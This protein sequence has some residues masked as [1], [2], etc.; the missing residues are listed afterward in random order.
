MKLYLISRRHLNSSV[1]WDPLF[2]LEN[3]I[4]DTCDATILA[5]RA[6]RVYQAVAPKSGRDVPVLRGI[7]RRTLGPYQACTLPPKKE[8]EACL[9]V[10]ISNHGLDVVRAVP[11]WRERFDLALAYMF[12]A[13]GDPTDHQTLFDR[14]YVPLPDAMGPWQRH[15]VKTTL[16]PFGV[17]AYE[18]GGSGAERPIDL[19]SYGRIP[20]AF[21]QAFSKRWN[22]AASSV[23]FVRTAPRNIEIY[24][25][26][27]YHDRDD[28]AD[29]SALYQLL[30]RSKASLCFDTA[31]PGMRKFPF[32]FVTLR[33]FDALGTGCAVVGKRPTTPEADRL[34][35]W[36]DSTVEIPDDP[37]AAVEMLEAFFADTARLERI[38]LRNY[39]E[40]LTRHDWRL[41]IR[42]MLQE[43]G[44]DLPPRLR[45]QLDQLEERADRAKQAAINAGALKDA[46]TPRSTTL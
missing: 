3:I 23:L 10:V 45:S 4:A 29:V 31:Y 33:W 44:L 35:P 14:I 15:G 25:E 22:R 43:V 11:G 12:D 20:R 37:S 9:S 32:S 38:R 7:V 16:L 39:Y 21:H 46:G 24:P 27:S 30:R 40:A 5:P 42:D 8:P 18:E 13:W 28:H 1:S 2:E 34:L 26:R 6:R 41:R 19:V 17:D 36:T